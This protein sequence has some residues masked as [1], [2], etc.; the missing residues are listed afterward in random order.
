MLRLF[1]TAR[2]DVFPLERREPGKVSMYVCG[3]TVYGPP[4]LGH[5]RMALVF[6]VLRRYLEW[7][8]DEVRYVSNV[9]DV[10]DNIINR[11]N[12]ESR[13]WHE[14]AE[15]CETFWWQ[16]MDG[17]GVKR[18]TKDP[19]AS[20]FIERMVELIGQLVEFGMAYETSDGVYF[21][22]ERVEDYGLLARQS[23]DSLRAGAR[24]EASDE[25]RS[26]VDFA[27]WKKAAPDELSWPSPWGP[28]RPGWHTECV[29]MALDLLGDGFDIHGGGQDLAFPH[30]ENERAQS[31]A[32]G[33]SFARYWVHN[34]FVEVEGEKMSKSL[35]NFTNLMDLIARADPR[36]YRLLVLR[37]HYRSPVEINETSVGDAVSALERLDAF[38][39]RT[40][41]LTG[42]P[43]AA[44][45][46]AFREAMDRD[47]DTPAV[48]SL[49]FDLVRRANS[50]LDQGDTDSAAPLAAAV[51]EIAG[52]VGLELRADADEVPEGVAELARQRDAARAAKD[53][54]TADALRDQLQAGGWVVEDGPTGTVVRRA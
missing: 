45:I 41:E 39:R 32:D 28:G 14:V 29:V 24:V 49:L 22:A 12:R 2:G 46:D 20:A 34:G 15:K 40:R 31:A 19:H 7:G 54:A 9:T 10:D 13:D 51:R 21:Q 38:A 33:R 27:L 36:S 42:E 50:L 48:S 44:A 16:A 17:L 47:L 3:P 35:G 8:G 43:D 6:D 25:K 53:W 26:P 4:H 11:A 37:S 30:H 23:L 1:D 52:A 18:P 5:G